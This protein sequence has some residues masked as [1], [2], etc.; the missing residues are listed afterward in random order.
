MFPYCEIDYGSE[1]DYFK[2]IQRLRGALWIRGF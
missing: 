2:N 1:M